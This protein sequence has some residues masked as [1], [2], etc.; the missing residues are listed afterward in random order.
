ME[1]DF[2]NLSAIFGDKFRLSNQDLSELLKM[3]INFWHAALS[4][5]FLLQYVMSQ[6]NNT[7]MKMYLPHKRTGQIHG[8][9]GGGGTHRLF[10][11][12]CPS[13]ESR[14]CPNPNQH[15]VPPPPPPPHRPTPMI[16][17]PHFYT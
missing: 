10:G 3:L 15:S 7:F 13:P 11:P 9:G 5:R 12:F 1:N 14:H 4:G 8:G 16:P 6:Q 17:P 2:R